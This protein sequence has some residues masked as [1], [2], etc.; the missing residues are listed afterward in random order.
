MLRLSVLSQTLLGFSSVDAFAAPKHLR[1]RFLRRL[2]LLGA[3]FA[4]SWRL[5]SLRA[6]RR[7]NCS[8]GTISIDGGTSTGRSTGFWCNSFTL[9][10]P[11]CIFHAHFFAIFQMNTEMFLFLILVKLVDMNMHII[12]LFTEVRAVAAP[13][14]GTREPRA[15][16]IMGINM[17]IEARFNVSSVRAVRAFYE[18][19]IEICDAS[20]GG[21]RVGRSVV[22]RIRRRWFD[23]RRSALALGHFRF[24]AAVAAMR[25]LHMRI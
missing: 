16:L 12:L 13:E 22:T 6:R 2:R 23:G 18:A 10:V 11:R 4:F 19:V 7:L 9:L 21:A 20:G 8:C 17:F 24:G 14:S 5:R 15:V 1:W 25:R 3:C